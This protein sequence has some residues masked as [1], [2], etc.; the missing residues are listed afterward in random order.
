MSG[1]FLAAIA[2]GNSI[3]YNGTITCGSAVIGGFTF[4]GFYPGLIVASSI[5]PSTLTTGY[6]IDKI[7][8]AT[9]PSNFSSISLSGFGSTDPLQGY[10]TDVTVNG[11]TKT[12]SSASGYSFSSGIAT[13]T[14]AFTWGIPISGTTPAIIR[15]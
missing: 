8:D 15:K 9:G 14:W 10:I 4:K 13:W 7:Y 12:S 6:A 2:G 3:I 1:I 11:V 5:S